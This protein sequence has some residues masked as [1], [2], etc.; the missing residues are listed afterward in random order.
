MENHRIPEWASKIYDE[1]TNL[2]TF[3]EFSFVGTREMSRLTSGYLLGEIIDRFNKKIE[4]SLKPN[5][6][7]S[8]YSGHD[9]TITSMMNLLDLLDVCIHIQCFY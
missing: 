8:L 9:T 7:L 4:G 5:L 1:L 3:E 6:S 2:A